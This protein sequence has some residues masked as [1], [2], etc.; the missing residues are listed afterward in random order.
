MMLQTGYYY[1]YIEKLFS[2]LDS[3][4]INK[5]NVIA[6]QVKLAFENLNS[7]GTLSQRQIFTRLSEWILDKIGYPKESINIVNILVAFFVQNC[8]VFYAIS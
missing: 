3:T 5:F 1:K 8:E 2:D 4:G 6:S 7:F